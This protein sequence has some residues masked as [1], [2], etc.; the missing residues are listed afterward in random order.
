[1]SRRTI[2]L[3]MPVHQWLMTHSLRETPI[4]RELRDAMEGHPEGEMQTSPEQVQLLSVLLKTMQASRVIEVGVFTGYSAMGMAMSLPDDG[5]LVACD[6][7]PEHMAVAQEWWDRAGVSDRIQP[8]VGPAADS[9][10]AMIDAG[11]AGTYDFIYVDADKTG[12]PEYYELGLQLLRPRG[13]LTFDNMLRGGRVAD[14]EINDES[15]VATRELAA[16]LLADD[17]VEY[18]LNPIGDGLAIAML[19]P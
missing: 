18:S 6:L 15:T 11:E 3:D 1:M 5:V 19:R 9:L 10:A 14:P 16:K 2:Q 12:Y 7:S 4:Q 13:L 8:R 17:R